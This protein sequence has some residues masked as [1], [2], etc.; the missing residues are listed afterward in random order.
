MQETLLL[1][2]LLIP[3]T[4]GRGFSLTKTWLEGKNPAFARHLNFP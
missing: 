2:I 4:I 3:Q 1:L